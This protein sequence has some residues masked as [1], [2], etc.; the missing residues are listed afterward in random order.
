MSSDLDRCL[1]GCDRECW[2]VVNDGGKSAAEILRE[3]TAFYDFCGGEGVYLDR[4]KTKG[5]CASCG[6]AAASLDV[7]LASIRKFALRVLA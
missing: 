7:D 4:M 6:R 5:D 1:F 2:Q 3:A